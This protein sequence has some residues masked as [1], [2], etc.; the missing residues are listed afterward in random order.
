MCHAKVLFDRTK[1][2]A[3]IV[4]VSSAVTLTIIPSSSSPKRSYVYKRFGVPLPPP[5]RNAAA[6]HVLILTQGKRP[7]YQGGNE[8]KGFVTLA[9]HQIV[10]NVGGKV[11]L[12]T[13]GRDRSF[14]QMLELLRTVDVQI[15]GPGSSHMNELFLGDG[16]VSIG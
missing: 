6:P 10:S 4:C 14:K 9:M 16:A 12:A 13:W 11:T 8:L 3:I 2:A 7:L 15:A 1:R 5:K